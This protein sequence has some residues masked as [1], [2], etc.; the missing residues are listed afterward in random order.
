MPKKKVVVRK[1]PKKK[2]I[3][4]KKKKTPK[5]APKSYRVAKN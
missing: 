5:R 1:K 3:V 2:V 4:R